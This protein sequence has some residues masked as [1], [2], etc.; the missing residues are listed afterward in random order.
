[1]TVEIFLLIAILVFVIGIAIVVD[2]IS[3]RLDQIDH[4]IDNNK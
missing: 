1:M 4:K 3:K 2:R